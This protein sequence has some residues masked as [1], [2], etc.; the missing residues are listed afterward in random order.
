M[1][2][3]RDARIIEDTYK[4]RQHGQM[5]M[6]HK[7]PRRIQ[8]RLAR[9]GVA[10]R[11]VHEII[12]NLCLVECLVFCRLVIPV[13]QPFADVD[14]A[15]IARQHLHLVTY[16]KGQVDNSS[17]AATVSLP[18]LNQRRF[19]LDFRTPPQKIHARY[20]LL[21]KTAGPK[22]SSD[23]V[24]H[25]QNFPSRPSLLSNYKQAP[26]LEGEDASEDQVKCSTSTVHAPR[27]RPVVRHDSSLILALPFIPT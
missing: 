10:G 1:C 3:R 23:E 24:D 8:R 4:H 5:R 2:K 6:R 20:D 18:H 16:V 7:Q 19:T 27:P 21:M 11:F 12:I 15:V 9:F 14:L 17:D 22:T 25:V 13:F 26:G